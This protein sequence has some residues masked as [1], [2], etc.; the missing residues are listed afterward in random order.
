MNYGNFGADKKRTASLP[1]NTFMPAPYPNKGSFAG[2][3]MHQSSDHQQNHEFKPVDQFRNSLNEVIRGRLNQRI[4]NQAKPG[5]TPNAEYL[6]NKRGSVFH[7]AFESDAA[8]KD[9][10]AP[11]YPKSEANLKSL[12]QLFTNSFLTKNIDSKNHLVLGKAMF[13]RNFSAGQSII[14]YGEMGSQYFVL[15][16]GQVRVTVYQPGTN[17]ADPEIA[18]KVAFEKVLDS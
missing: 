11:V 6:K 2:F 9:F 14:R 17:A 10:V 12:V 1:T 7:R 8:I 16:K 5:F 4:F 15:S 13:V 3:S 18:E